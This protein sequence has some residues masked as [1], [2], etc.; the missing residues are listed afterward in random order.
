MG[1][2]PREPVMNKPLSSFGPSSWNL[3]LVA[4]IVLAL[5]IVHFESNVL[6]GGGW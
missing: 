6:L 5:T 1:W 2:V 3:R 4:R